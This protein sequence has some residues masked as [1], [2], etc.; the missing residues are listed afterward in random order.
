MIGILA[1]TVKFAEKTAQYL[2]NAEVKFSE[3]GGGP[4][5]HSDSDTFAGWECGEVHIH[6]ST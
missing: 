5:R 3:G 4:Q 2:Q 6:V 1:C